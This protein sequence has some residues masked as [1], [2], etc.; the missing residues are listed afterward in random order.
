[1]TPISNASHPLLKI[2]SNAIQSENI[3]L[4]D[5]KSIKQLYF[6]NGGSASDGYF[7]TLAPSGENGW[8]IGTVV[9]QLDFTAHIV[10]NIKLISGLIFLV[11]LVCCAVA[12]YLTQRL[13]INP[14]NTIIAQTRLVKNFELA[15]VV[16]VD[17]RINEIHLLSSSIHQ[18]AHG[19]SSFGKF[20]PLSLVKLLLAQGV[21]AD[22]SGENRT[23]SIFF[24]DMVSF[25]TISEEMG[26]KLLPHLGRY[27]SQMSDIVARHEGTID[28][29]IGDAIMAF[30]GAPLYNE[31]H[32]LACC[33]AAVE[34]VREVEVLREAW[35]EKFREHFGVRIGVNTGRVIVGNIGS[36]SRLNYTVLGDPVNLAARLE[37]AGKDYGVACIIGLNTYEL[38][39]YDIVSRKLDVVTVKGK[40]DAVPIYELLDMADTEPTEDY[41][42]IK[43]FEEGL[44]LYFNAHWLPARACFER[45]I[46]L[47]GKDSPSEVFIK[48]CEAHINALA[49][50]A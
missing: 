37:S 40:L 3:S 11:V 44:A 45:T 47:R 39:R 29:Y 46:A 28:K 15:S 25:T 35:P 27:M 5:L 9:P 17:T 20:I 42:W 12:V 38:T 4:K 49:L 7:V 8:I 31:D 34:C 24:M 2:V 21:R 18:M 13:F 1:M 19:L 10:E 48:R 16:T 50:H 26:P 22:V 36:S 23:L 14:L 6:E 41:G 32:A 43:V 30:W 33:R